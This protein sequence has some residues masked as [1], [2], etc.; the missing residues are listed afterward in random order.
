LQAYLDQMS[1]LM[2]H[3][4]LRDSE[5]DSEAR[6]LARARTLTVLGRL[7]PDRKRTVVRFLYESA[8]DSIRKP[9]S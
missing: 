8:L 3:N 4:N 5:E 2:L 1:A 6:R 7:G 9:P